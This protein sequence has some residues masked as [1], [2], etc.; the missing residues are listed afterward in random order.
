VPRLQRRVLG[1]LFGIRHRQR[2][3]VR[4]AEGDGRTR[5]HVY[6]FVGAVRTGLRA[7]Q[8]RG[9]WNPRQ[10]RAG[11]RITD[12]ACQ[13]AWG[14]GNAQFP[15]H[16]PRRTKQR[17][18]VL[19]RK[20]SGEITRGCNLQRRECQCVQRKCPISSCLYLV[21]VQSHGRARDSCPRAL[22]DDQTVQ[23]AAY[24]AELR[25]GGGRLRGHGHREGLRH[26]SGQRSLQD[27]GATAQRQFE[28]SVLGGGGPASSERHLNAW[29]RLTGGIIEHATGKGVCHPPATGKKQHGSAQEQ[30]RNNWA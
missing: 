5:L 2:A 28:L 8:R 6:K 15:A 4:A 1:S 27:V 14:Q 30:H 23:G 11:R 21:A 17:G 26:I 12:D 16:D 24:Q 7:A 20:F 18:N 19:L 29:Q 10:R 13:H 25:A 3:I 22:I 9:H